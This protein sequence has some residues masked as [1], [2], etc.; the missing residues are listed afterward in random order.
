MKKID[1]GLNRSDKILF[2]ISE[3]DKKLDIGEKI[4]HETMV[5]KVWKMFPIDFCMK[6]HLEYPNSDISK[7]ITKLFKENLLKGNVYNYMITTKGKEY[8]EKINFK[9]ETHNDSNIISSS[10]QI[11]AEI[12]RIN[13]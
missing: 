13:S 7:Y 11:D 4:S 3:L 6:G 8:V 5:I 2:A 1:G 9:K 12:K 10:R